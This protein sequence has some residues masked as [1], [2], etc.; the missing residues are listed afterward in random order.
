MPNPLARHGNGSFMPSWVPSVISVHAVA[1]SRVRQLPPATQLTSAHTERWIL[2]RSCAPVVDTI[3]ARWKA[4][5]H[6]EMR[7]LLR[8]VHRRLRRWP[9]LDAR[10]Q[11]VACVSR[12]Y[13]KA[14]RY[15]FEISFPPWSCPVAGFRFL[16]LC[17]TSEVGSAPKTQTLLGSYGSCQFRLTY[18]FGSIVVLMQPAHLK[19]LTC[20][21][22][23]GSDQ[24]NF[25]DHFNRSSK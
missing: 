23:Y 22:Y 24:R 5:E 9:M 20:P 4:A 15:E 13:R 8:G 12:H 2:F 10:P 16:R 18:D 25:L 11:S 6:S 21:C 1:G 3:W 17:T 19:L 14:W 7:V